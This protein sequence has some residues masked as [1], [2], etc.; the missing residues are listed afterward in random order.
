[1]K[2]LYLLGLVLACSV[3]LPVGAQSQILF[4]M[5]DGN[6]VYTANLDGSGTPT[7]LI[8][9]AVGVDV[10]GIFADTANDLLY[11]NDGNGRWTYVAPLSGGVSGTQ[12]PNSNPP[13]SEHFM[14]YVDVPNGRYFFC[15][16]ETNG[17]W[18]A[19]TDGTGVTSQVFTSGD[20]PGD[21]PHGV[22]Y[23]PATDTLYV[24]GLTGA[25][26]IWSA[27][28]STG[29]GTLLYDA[30]D[31][32][33]GARGLRIDPAAGTLYW[34]Q[35]DAGTAGTGEVWSANMDGTGSPTLLY[36]VPDPY[37]AADVLPD[38]TSGLLY[39]SEYDRNTTSR[40]MVAPANGSGIPSVLHTTTAGGR[41][42]GLAFGQ[43]LIATA[44]VPTMGE[45]GLIILTLLLLTAGMIA[46]RRARR[47]PLPG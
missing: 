32:V 30:A 39:W 9:G 36:N 35:H 2:K 44:I 26:G 31:G 42:R 27:N 11:M 10:V 19:N 45:W 15:S 28:V 24:A 18:V 46:I 17:V 23:D 20:I 47:V 21:N 22:D 34:V 3:S 38:P 40:I 25:S 12:L 4:G 1:M 41:M 37:L 29:V 16:D 8:A 33:T 6:S 14:I 5:A 13:G 7:L 43:P